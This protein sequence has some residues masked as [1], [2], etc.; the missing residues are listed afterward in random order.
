LIDRLKNDSPPLPLRYSRFE[1]YAYHTHGQIALKEGTEESARRAVAHFEKELEVY[2]AI[3]DV[4]AVFVAKTL[5]AN[6]RSIYE[7][8]NTEEVLKTYKELYE[9]RVSVFGEKSG[10]SIIAGRNYAIQLQK[11]N[12]GYEACELLTKLQAM[13]K[14]NYGPDH[15]HTKDVESTLKWV[16]SKINVANQG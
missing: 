15:N 1:G 6:A 11:A 4:D 16:V 3:G 13:S 14:Q 7:G 2:N 12:R 10:I 5:I 9:L 8:V